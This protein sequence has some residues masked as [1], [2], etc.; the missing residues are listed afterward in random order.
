MFKSEV[1]KS[2]DEWMIS[3]AMT[4]TKSNNPRAPT[5]EQ[6]LGWLVS[7]WDSIPAE[8]I[9]LSF[10]GRHY[11]RSLSVYHLFRLRPHHRAGWE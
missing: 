4:Y 10:K 1:Q 5:P 8:L 11:Q 2:Y 9:S 7:A 6:Y 3:G